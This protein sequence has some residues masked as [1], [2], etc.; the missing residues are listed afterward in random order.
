MDGKKF[1]QLVPLSLQIGTFAFRIR[2]EGY[3]V[4][5]DGT[6][7]SKPKKHGQENER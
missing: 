2:D 4:T 6:I 3:Y 5:N 7:D 1:D